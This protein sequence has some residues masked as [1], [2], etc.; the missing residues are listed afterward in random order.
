MQNDLILFFLKNRFF[1]C[2]VKENR[3]QRILKV[4]VIF[5]S[6]LG[7]RFLLNLIYFVNFVKLYCLGIKGLEKKK[8]LGECGIC[9]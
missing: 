4:E 2:F 6:Y 8:D 1:F 9:F 3:V 5:R 7:Y